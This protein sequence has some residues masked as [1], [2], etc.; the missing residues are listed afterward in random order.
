MKNT[1]INLRVDDDLKNEAEKVFESIGLTTS[2]AILLYLKAVI[3]EKR[4]PFSLVANDED[5]AK[6]ERHA[7]STSTTK[8]PEPDLAPVTPTKKTKIHGKTSLRQ[9]IEKL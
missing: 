9:A 2:A 8:K 5:L 3:R 1:I 4:I 7:A 6:K